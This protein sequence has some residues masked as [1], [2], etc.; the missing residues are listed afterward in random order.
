MHFCSYNACKLHAYIL[1]SVHRISEGLLCAL[2]HKRDHLCSIPCLSSS[3][4]PDL[5]EDRNLS[6]SLFP[7]HPE[8]LLLVPSS[9][10][11]FTAQ[12]DYHLRWLK[13]A[14]IG[15][16]AFIPPRSSLH[17]CI[18]L[19]FLSVSLPPLAASSTSHALLVNP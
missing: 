1:S 18:A 8:P 16:S 14:P 4:T 9:F 5:C 19:R 2:F 3:V 6:C 17:L 10:F 13:Q 11:S 12:P 7:S 15:R